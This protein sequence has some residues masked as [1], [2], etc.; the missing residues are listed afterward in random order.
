M[1]LRFI[2]II[3]IRFDVLSNSQPARFS[4]NKLV[5]IR[6]PGD[7]KLQ[8]ADIL[9]SQSFADTQKHKIFLYTIS[10]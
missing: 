5:D 2:Y 6:G 3:Y 10:C 1:H 9:K 4:L 7:E 8:E